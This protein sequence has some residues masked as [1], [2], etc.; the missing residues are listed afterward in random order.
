LAEG[1]AEQSSSHS[2]ATVER[3]RRWG[4]LRAFLLGIVVGVVALFVLAA[5][6]PH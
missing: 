4:A 3:R 1:S 2:V 6:N 5:I